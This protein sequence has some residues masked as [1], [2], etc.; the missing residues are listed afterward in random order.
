MRYTAWHCLPKPARFLH[1]S[2]WRCEQKNLRPLESIAETQP[3]LQPDALISWPGLAL[4]V[5]LL[6]VDR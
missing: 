3:Q 4:T 2:H 5:S 6:S 1:A